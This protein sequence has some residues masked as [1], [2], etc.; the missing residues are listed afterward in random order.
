M[1]N[2]ARVRYDMELRMRPVWYATGRGSLFR[3]NRSTV[4]GASFHYLKDE[5]ATIA[6][7]VLPSRG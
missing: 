2:D 4:P 5:I 7:V 1:W 3:E 6:I